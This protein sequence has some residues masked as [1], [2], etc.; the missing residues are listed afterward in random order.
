MKT[1]REIFEELW[2]KPANE[3]FTPEEINIIKKYIPKSKYRARYAIYKPVSK[4]DLYIGFF[5]DSNPNATRRSG[6]EN[7]WDFLYEREITN[8]EYQ[9]IIENYGCNNRRFHAYYH[10]HIEHLVNEDLKYNVTT[11]PGFV[12]ECKRL[13]YTGDFQLQ[14]NFF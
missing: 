14:M 3:K 4:K 7:H 8:I 13:G 9:E 2:H 11:P 12:K 5:L 10:R 1:S 6:V